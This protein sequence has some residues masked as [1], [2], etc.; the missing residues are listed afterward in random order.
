MH[1]A[2]IKYNDIA[3]GPG[4]RTTVFVSGCTHHCYNCFNQVA[5][6]FKYGKEYN[7]SI[8]E[9]VLK[10]LESDYI[11][12]LTL[13]GGEPMEKV[14]QEGLISLVRKAKEKYP[15]KTIWCF[16]GYLF[17][18]L[19]PNGSMHDKYTDELLSLIDVIVDGEYLDAQ[20]DVSLIFK[21]SRN[22]RTIDVKSSLEKK[23]II[24]LDLK[25]GTL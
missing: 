14:N 24:E 2:E 13:L 15:N 18:D 20:K 22:Q 5:W 25:K 10:S 12:G 17:E 6:D 3:N 9:E 1:I 11:S 21:G 19:L 16:T 23:T 7:S 8:E 4:V